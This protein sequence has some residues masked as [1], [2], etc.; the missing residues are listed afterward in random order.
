M[1]TQM[2]VV[3]ATYDYVQTIA[4][5]FFA[6]SFNIDFSNLPQIWPTSRQRDINLTDKEFFYSV[7][8]SFRQGLTQSLPALIF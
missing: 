5:L 7:H 4:G 6:H 2:D 8:G 1:Y 3:S